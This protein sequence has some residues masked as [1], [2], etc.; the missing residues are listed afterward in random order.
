MTAI[1]TID[2]DT[3]IGAEHS[4]NLFTLRKNG[5]RRTF[6]AYVRACSHLRRQV[7][8]CVCAEATT[9]EE[10]RRLEVVGLFH[11]G[12]F[13][14]AFRPGSLVMQLPHQDAG[15]VPAPAIDGAAGGGAMDLDQAPQ[16]EVAASAAPAAGGE[17]AAKAPLLF[18]SVNGA[19]GVVA[20]LPPSAPKQPA[21]RETRH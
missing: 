15:A 16:G 21:L 17:P 6:P 7:P 5:G 10:K 20:Q 19:I 4:C 14:N 2:E 8:R 18:A 9:E 12:E 1:S 11:V 3:F 13:V